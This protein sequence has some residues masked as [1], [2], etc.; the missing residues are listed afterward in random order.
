MA[1]ERTHPDSIAILGGDG[2]EKEKRDFLER[3]F[4]IRSGLCPNGCGL[5]SYADGIQSCAKCNFAC[6]IRP[7][8]ET[9]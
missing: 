6:N 1:V 5:M 4:R 2:T 3:D 9:Q 8:L 7:E